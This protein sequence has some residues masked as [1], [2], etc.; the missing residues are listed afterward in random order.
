MS[1]GSLPRD[2]VINVITRCRVKVTEVSPGM[3]ELASSEHTET[4]SLPEEVRKRTLHYISNHYP[5]IP[6]HY[7]YN[8][9]K[10]PTSIDEAPAKKPAAGSE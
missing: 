6:I 7:F 4:I 1:D 10:I 8:P 2:R 9:D 5:G 3:Y